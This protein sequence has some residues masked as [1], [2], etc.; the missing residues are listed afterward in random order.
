MSWQFSRK[1]DEVQIWLRWSRKSSRKN[2]IMK[3][4]RDAKSKLIVPKQEVEGQR[5]FQV[6]SK[7]FSNNLLRYIFFHHTIDEPSWFT[8]TSKVLKKYTLEKI[9]S[10]RGI[11]W[12]IY[13]HVL[14][15]RLYTQANHPKRR[16]TCPYG[17]IGSGIW[18]RQCYTR[19]S[20]NCC[21]LF[22]L[23]ATQCK[24]NEKRYRWRIFLW[25]TYNPLVVTINPC[26]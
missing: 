22:G 14:C 20:E 17:C 25:D 23:A 15:S 18:D 24:T 5:I 12:N 16:P 3:A 9:A 6:N 2:K 4:S 13:L 10:K 21:S 8:K 1:W 7:K 11:H 19:R 26:T